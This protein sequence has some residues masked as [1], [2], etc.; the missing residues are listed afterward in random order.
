MDIS[1]KSLILLPLLDDEFALMSIIKAFSKKNN[2]NL[3]IVYC[4][5][6][7]ND[8]SFNIEKGRIK[9]YK[10][11][12]IIGI[13]KKNIIYLNDFFEIKSEFL[14]SNYNKVLNLS[15]NLLE[16]FL[17]SNYLKVTVNVNDE[18]SKICKDQ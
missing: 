7:T 13:Q 17:K 11:L 4:A 9:N 1:L 6:I 3:K 12:K 10:A 15:S 2:N 5:D 8:K 14:I 16:Q 18:L